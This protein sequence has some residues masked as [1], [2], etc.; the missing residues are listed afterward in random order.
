VTI[1][2]ADADPGREAAA[3]EFC[4]RFLSDSGVPRYVQGANRHAASIAAQVDVDGFIDDFSGAS[5][6]CGKPVVRTEQAPA[7]ALIVSAVLGKVWTARRRLV[8][9][10]LE[11][12][13]YYAF[14]KH[15]DLPIANPF[16][17]DDF[18]QEFRANTAAYERLYA[19]LADDLSRKTLR[20]IVNFRLSSDIGWMQGYTD[21]QD[22]QYFEDFLNL[23]EQG[24]TFVD[25]GGFDGFT[26]QEF[27]SRCPGYDRVHLFEPEPSNMALAK[28]RLTP[29]RD[30]CF[31]Q[32]GLS[33]RPQALRLSRD[34]STSRL[35][36]TGDVQI[37]LDRLDAVIDEPVTFIKMDI[38]GA[39][40][41]AIAGG[42]QLIRRFTPRLA[43]AAY[44]RADDFHRLP[45]QVLAING[46]Y[47][48]CLRHY[49]E[50]R[51]E[52]VLFFIPRT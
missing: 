9:A 45:E 37:A 21:R 18:G 29:C 25:V 39:E 35:S 43:I 48:L 24:E 7:G 52:T 8:A 41:P 6:F 13:D 42:A 32:M 4:R 28:A 44:H 12:I 17:W 10:G 31:H 51:D 38:E 34:G 20:D 36:S 27:I 16:F 40:R 3:A 46:S 19:T 14:R 23:A 2:S 49:T 5:A 50:C 15:S 22:R 30:V 1:F 33:D 26:S 11:C 47:D